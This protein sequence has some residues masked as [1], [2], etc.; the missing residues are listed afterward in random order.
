MILSLAKRGDYFILLVTL[1]EI[2]SGRHFI[3]LYPNKRYLVIIASCNYDG[4]QLRITLADE[5]RKNTEI[6]FNFATNRLKEN[7]FKIISLQEER[8]AKIKTLY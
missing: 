7:E 5:E 4:S 2:T 3:P 8:I 6:I 1:R